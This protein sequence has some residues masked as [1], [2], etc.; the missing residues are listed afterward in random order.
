MSPRE[1]D[2]IIKAG[3]KVAVEVKPGLPFGGERFTAV[4]V[5]RDRWNIYTDEG[6]V[7]DRGDLILFRE[8]E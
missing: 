1:A 8:T 2:R 3:K 4:F 6:A 7:F 5:R